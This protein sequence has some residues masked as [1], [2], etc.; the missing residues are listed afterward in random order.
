M[1]RT[2]SKGL[3]PTSSF[4]DDGTIL[5]GEASVGFGLSTVAWG[6]M[7]GSSIPERDGSQIAGRDAGSGWGATAL[8]GSAQLWFN[9]PQ[10]QTVII[11][12]S[13]RVGVFKWRFS[14]EIL[15]LQQRRLSVMNVNS[16]MTNGDHTSIHFWTNVD[17]WLLAEQKNCVAPA[18]INVPLRARH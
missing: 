16:V 2:P 14:E 13:R 15:F 18:L 5:E 4:G 12:L 7:L 11:S 17:S 9:L 3:G 8:P 10:I 6:W 1:R